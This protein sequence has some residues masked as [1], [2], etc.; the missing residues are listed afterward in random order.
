MFGG[1]A[2]K[3]PF[4]AGGVLAVGGV[5]TDQ[6][7]H[8][9]KGTTYKTI[10][11]GIGWFRRADGTCVS[12]NYSSL[13]FETVAAH[14]LGSTLGLTAAGVTRNPNDA[15]PDDDRFALMVPSYLSVPSPFLG[16]DDRDA[17]CYLYGSCAGVVE[18]KL[19][20]P[21]VGSVEGLNG[22]RFS[23]EMALTNRSTASS[24]A[25]IEY[26]PAI[27]TG[28]G[29]VTEVVGAG[30]QVVIPDVIA[31]LRTKGLAIAATG[32]AAGTLRVSFPG[33]YAYDAAVTVRT[34]TAVPP[35]AATPIGRAGLAY[36]GVSQERLL[37][38][39][40][41]L[42]GLRRDAADRTNIALQ[43][44]GAEADGT[45]AFAPPGTRRRAWPARPPSSG[46]SRRAGG[47]SST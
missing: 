27:G 36:V 4:S 23:S 15:N 45:S 17:I 41:W 30:R 24:T 32:D 26:T 21:F 47:R 42:L 25:V 22:S 2:I 8:A 34:T 16:S 12:G 10:R 5:V 20:V 14:V 18:A 9:F 35:G 37:L 38:E 11:A 7:A 29:S 6:S 43:N 19:F 33:V 3:C 1:T 44:A 28:K 40:A 39:P 31:W 46:R 13:L